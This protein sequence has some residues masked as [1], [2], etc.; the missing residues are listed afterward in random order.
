L[1]ALGIASSSVL[2]NVPIYIV[3]ATD[4]DGGKRVR[5][6]EDIGIVEELAS[7]F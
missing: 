1:L 5:D 6:T 3:Y 7:M 2:G 4:T